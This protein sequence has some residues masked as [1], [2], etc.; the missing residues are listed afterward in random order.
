MGKIKEGFRNLENWCLNWNGGITVIECKSVQNGTVFI[1][2]KNGNHVSLIANIWREVYSATTPYI[3]ETVKADPSKIWCSGIFP[4]N[5]PCFVELA[6]SWCTTTS[7]SY[8]TLVRCFRFTS[9]RYL[10]LAAS[11]HM[12]LPFNS[13]QRKVK[14]QRWV[15]LTLLLR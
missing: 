6:V 10:S 12:F 5:V 1:F 9:M 8:F 4:V 7:V 14:R 13:T 11:G 15:M 3:Y 2:E